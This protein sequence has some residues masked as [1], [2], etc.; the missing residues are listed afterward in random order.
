MRTAIAL[1]SNIGNRQEALSLAR[2]AV[3]QLPGVSGPYCC[4]S[5][6]ETEPVDA[7]PGSESFLN[8]VIEFKFEGEPDALLADLQAIEKNMGRPA[9]RAVNSPRV[10]DLDILYAGGLSLATPS[11]PLPHP[12]LHLRRFVLEPLAEI[13]P[14]FR[15]FGH[16][17]TVADLLTHLE[18][19][20]HVER[21]RLQWEP[22]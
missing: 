18:D 2:A 12:R 6:Y 11:L 20:A 16:T 7:T 5:L 3:L 17:K 19:P 8:A 4:S 22:L 13:L 9:E 10:I 1:G 21:A 15:M 14:E